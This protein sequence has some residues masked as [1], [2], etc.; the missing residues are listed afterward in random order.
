[1]ANAPLSGTG[2]TAKATDL[3]EKKSGNFLAARL[4]RPNHLRI[5]SKNRFTATRIRILRPIPISSSNSTL[6]R[7]AAISTD[8]AC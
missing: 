3:P 2:R 7:R 1:M 6:R 8:D 5:T 4:D